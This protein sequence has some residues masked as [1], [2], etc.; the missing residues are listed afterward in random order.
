MRPS[1]LRWNVERLYQKHLLYGK[2][3]R[4][5]VGYPCYHMV[6]PLDPLCPKTKKNHS[7]YS[8]AEKLGGQFPTLGCILGYQPVCIIQMNNFFP[9]ARRT[10]AALA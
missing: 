7:L 9:T 2:I 1:P 6:F 3:S 4:V 5:F 8:I 10:G